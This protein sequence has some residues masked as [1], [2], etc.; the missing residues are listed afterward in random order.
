MEWLFDFPRW[1]KID[2]T[3]IDRAV[4]NFAIFAEGPL[5]AIKNGINS[6]VGF[7]AMILNHI[8]WPVFI[9][10]VAYLGWRIRKKVLTGLLYGALVF[11]I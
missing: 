1:F 2:V 7:M 11:L 6:L 8:P 10:L 9:L 4:R 5:S 3:A